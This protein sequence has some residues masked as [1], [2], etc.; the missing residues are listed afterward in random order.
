[1]RQPSRQATHPIPIEQLLEP[2]GSDSFVK[3][4]SAA[5]V[6][7]VTEFCDQQSTKQA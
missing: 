4:Q 1:M 6:I 5:W 7:R 3:R 2:H